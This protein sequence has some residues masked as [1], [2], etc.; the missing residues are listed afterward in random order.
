[1]A[2]ASNLQL[3]KLLMLNSAPGYG[4]VFGALEATA[5]SAGMVVQ[6]SRGPPTSVVEP[7]VQV[8]VTVSASWEVLQK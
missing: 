6:G 4:D 8:E 5:A 3:G 2:K 1:M 7:F